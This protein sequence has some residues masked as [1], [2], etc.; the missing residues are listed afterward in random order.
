MTNTTLSGFLYSTP[1]KPSAKTLLVNFKKITLLYQNRQI[2]L[3][4]K[5]LLFLHNPPYLK[6]YNIFTVPA[7]HPINLFKI[8]NVKINTLILVL[9]RT[10][11]LNALQAYASNI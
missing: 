6:K 2:R 9:Q 7:L 5:I 8:Y 4:N 1:H 11:I 10:V 3:P